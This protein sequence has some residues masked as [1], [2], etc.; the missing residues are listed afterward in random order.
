MKLR[1]AGITEFGSNLRLIDPLGYLEFLWLQRHAAAVVTD[2]G[3]IQEETTYLGIPCLTMRANTER[4]VT[5]DV[6]TNELIGQDT[7][8][9]EKRLVDSLRGKQKKG[10]IP[11]LWDGKAGERVADVVEKV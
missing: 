1:E 8:L 7:D 2:S 10:T 3:G 5:V 11:P 6:G 9:M 4:P